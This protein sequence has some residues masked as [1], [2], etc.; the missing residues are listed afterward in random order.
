MS[1]ISLKDLANI[2]SSAAI[3]SSAAAGAIAKATGT[4]I[5]ENAKGKL[6]TY[7]PA[8]GGFPAWPQLAESTQSQREAKGYTPNDPLLR[9][10]ALRESI[11][12]RAE[13]NAAIVGTTEDIGLYMENGTERIPPRPFLGPAAEEEVDKIGIISAP[14]IKTIFRR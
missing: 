11:T 2:F 13:G 7:Q 5:M 1:D 10:G 14:I 12:M 6:G 3:R 8:S 4:A 9:S